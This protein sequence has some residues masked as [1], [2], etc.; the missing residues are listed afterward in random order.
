[1]Q[2]IGCAPGG[3]LRGWAPLAP[4]SPSGSDSLRG[5]K[6]YAL[7]AGGGSFRR[8]PFAAS[9]CPPRRCGGGW[10]A[11]PAPACRG[12][13]PALAPVAPGAR[14]A[15]CAQG[16]LSAAS[17]RPCAPLCASPLCPRPF[18]RSR[19]APGR[20]GASSR[21]CALGGALASGGG[22]GAP[23]P[24]PPPGG[25]LDRL[26]SEVQHLKIERQHGQTCVKCNHHKN[27]YKE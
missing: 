3:A 23:L 21:P 25:S 11:A 9:P 5:I 19:G 20:C 27:S 24:R 6:M 4:R 2:I 16:F 14:R 15:V 17:G 13:P 26:S 1:M 22:A 7:S 8:R 10:A 18:P 12:F